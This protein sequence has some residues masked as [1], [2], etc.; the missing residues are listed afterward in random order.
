MQGG[1]QCGNSHNFWDFSGRDENVGILWEF[2]LFRPNVGIL[3]FQTKIQ[4][5][6]L[7]PP[8]ICLTGR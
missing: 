1:H 6:P 7:L 3:I 4:K 8:Q 5:F 2:G